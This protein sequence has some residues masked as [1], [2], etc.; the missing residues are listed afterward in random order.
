MS[1]MPVTIDG[2]SGAADHKL[3]RIYWGHSAAQALDYINRT[4]ANHARV[5]FHDAT[6]DAYWM[7]RREGRIRRDIGFARSIEASDATLF[8]EQKF[9][10]ARKLEIQQAYGVPGPTW[11]WRV[12]GVPIVSVYARPGPRETI[13]PSVRGSRPASPRVHVPRRPVPRLPSPPPARAGPGK[14]ASSP[15]ALPRR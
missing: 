8:E 13:A 9:F 3:T 10:A 7:Y 4:L 5:W 14:P 15:T 2:V 12:E 11:S 6:Y 1:T